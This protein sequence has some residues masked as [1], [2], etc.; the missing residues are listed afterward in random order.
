MISRVP[1]FVDALTTAPETVSDTAH[2]PSYQVRW[3][4]RSNLAQWLH[5]WTLWLRGRIY[6]RLL[7]WNAATVAFWISESPFV[8]AIASTLTRLRIFDRL[9][10]GPLTAAALADAT[11]TDEDTLLRFLRAAATLGIL[12]RESDGRFALSPVGRQFLSDSP[13]P[14]SAWTELMDRQVVAG[15][16]RLVECLKRGEPPSK[17]IHGK[18][19]WEVMADDPGCTE[20]HDI[21]CG[22]WGELIVDRVAEAYDFTNV[23]TV[24]DVGGG[25]GAFL[26]AMLR[27]A[28]HLR[29]RVYDRETTH[30]PAQKMFEKHGVTDRAAHECGNFF[31]S[32]PAG[33]DL[34]TIKHV[35]HDWDDEHAELILRNIRAA[36]PAHGKLLIVEGSVDHNLLPAP[37][38]LAI[39]DVTQFGITWGKSRTLEEFSALAERAGFRLANVFVT[40]TIDGLILECEPIQRPRWEQPESV[41]VGA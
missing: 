35:L 3:T 27:A 5:K 29:G 13:N 26:S 20:L 38:V 39:W 34:Y 19:C 37:S 21:A 36:V 28:P 25:R 11:A 30:E 24:I 14:V 17:V 18:T 9:Q 15:I 6:R 10:S 16:P 12:D 23:K 33:A 40:E 7:S 31:E 2:A 41:S 1:N 32:V 22:G 4:K 8:F